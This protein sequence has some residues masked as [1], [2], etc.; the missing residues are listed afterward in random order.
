M[1]LSKTFT[2]SC[3]VPLPFFQRY[4]ISTQSPTQLWGSKGSKVWAEL[5]CAN[6]GAS[7]HWLEVRACDP[8]GIAR[9]ISNIFSLPF[10]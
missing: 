7:L 1:S 9:G 8:T 6:H 4:Y 5:R 3:P 2:I 10:F